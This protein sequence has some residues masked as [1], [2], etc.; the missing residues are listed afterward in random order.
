MLC[1]DRILL[2]FQI[3]F[4]FENSL[5]FRI[6]EKWFEHC[7]IAVDDEDKTN[8]ILCRV[9]CRLGRSK[10]MSDILLIRFCSVLNG[11]FPN[12]Y[13]RLLNFPYGTGFSSLYHTCI[14]SIT[15]TIVRTDSNR[16]LVAADSSYSR[17][18][19]WTTFSNEEGG[20][21]KYDHGKRNFQFKIATE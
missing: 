15:L 1:T 17:L 8:S 11:T 21:G 14:G 4:T 16:E 5:F 7:K 9:T 10:N 13:Q 19:R 3:Y 18:C 6:I 2:E 12:S 20:T